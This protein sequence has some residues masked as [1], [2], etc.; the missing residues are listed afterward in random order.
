MTEAILRTWKHIG[1]NIPLIQNS[2]KCGYLPPRAVCL[3]QV[4]GSHLPPTDGLTPS[5]TVMAV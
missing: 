3:W 2:V 4:W 5:M 1:P